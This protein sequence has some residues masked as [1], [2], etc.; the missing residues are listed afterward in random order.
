MGETAELF[1]L[2]GAVCAASIGLSWAVFAALNRLR[3][4]DALPVGASALLRAKDGVLRSRMIDRTRRGLLFHAPVARDRPME[5]RPGEEVAI[6]STGPLG[7]TLFRSHVIEIDLTR[8]T[9]EIATP[10]EVFRVERRESRRIEWRTGQPI[11]VNGEAARLVDLSERGARIACERPP[12]RGERL[13]IRF[14]WSEGEL[15]AWIVSSASERTALGFESR[16]IFEELA[17]LADAGRWH[18]RSLRQTPTSP[19]VLTP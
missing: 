13:R 12:G 17:S 1:G 19:S 3:R 4:A 14:P 16:A 8:G 18:K 10:R 7:Q 5:L 2:Y 9:F 6:Q 11:A 15:Y